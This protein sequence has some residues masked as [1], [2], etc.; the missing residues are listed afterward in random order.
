MTKL[1]VMSVG[2]KILSFNVVSLGSCSKSPTVTSLE[3]WH[4]VCSSGQYPTA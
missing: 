4:K 3:E 2:A 1:H